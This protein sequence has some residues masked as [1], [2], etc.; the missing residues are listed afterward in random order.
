M[1]SSLFIFYHDETL[2]SHTQKENDSQSLAEDTETI[3][4]TDEKDY[5]E[6]V[7]DEEKQQSILVKYPCLI[8]ERE[9]KSERNLAIH[10][11]SEHEGI[12]TF[13]QS[14]DNEQLP[15]NKKKVEEV[16]E[17]FKFPCDKCPHQAKTRSNLKAHI[18]SVHDK[19]D[20][21]NQNRNLKTHIGTVH[22]KLQ[23]PCNQCEKQFKT[24]GSMKR[25]IESVHE[26]VRYPCNQCDYKATRQGHLKTHIKSV[27][28]NIKYPCNQ[29]EYKATQQSSL[30]NHVKSVHEKVKYPCNLCQYQATTQGSLR[31]HLKSVHESKL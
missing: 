22:K 20:L 13:E 30:K 19:V 2:A 23:Y 24:K 3:R 21:S 28:E 27:H 7:Y 17:G 4:T 6:F 16:P 15:L 29:C 18:R 14:G 25:H 26:K 8:C 9:F 12:D 11:N 1:E 10:T 31:R 5:F